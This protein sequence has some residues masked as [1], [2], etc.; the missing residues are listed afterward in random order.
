LS[1]DPAIAK[2]VRTLYIYTSAVTVLE[3]WQGRDRSLSI[4][5]RL[6]K[7]KGLASQLLLPSKS[8]VNATHRARMSARPTRLR[9][10]QV[11][12]LL[13]RVASQLVNVKNYVLDWR[14]SWETIED[15]TPLYLQTAWDTMGH[16]LR[17]LHLFAP[18]SKFLAVSTSWHSVPLESNG[19][20]RC[21]C[22]LFNNH[23]TTLKAITIASFAS[24]DMSSFFTELGQPQNP[25]CGD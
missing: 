3:S 24:L 7:I 13:M 25:R 19:L 23:R 4:P 18:P 1:R 9:T 17:S 10:S 14:G 15:P 2:R 6:S 12:A 11:V 5:S 20:S 21:L 8:K 22:P 16:N